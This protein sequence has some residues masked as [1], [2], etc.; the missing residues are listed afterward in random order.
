M[1]GG[2]HNFLPN[3]V[4]DPDLGKGSR[5]DGI[6]LIQS[7]A[8]DKKER[9]A[10]YKFVWNREQLLGINTPPDYLLG[11]NLFELGFYECPEM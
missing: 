3:N 10:D 8:N 4:S 6:N 5:T 7:W 11:T 2:Y 1:G 9:N